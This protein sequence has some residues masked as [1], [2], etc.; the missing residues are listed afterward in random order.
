MSAPVQGKRA[1]RRAQRREDVLDAAM[2]IIVGEG[3]EALTIQRL[4]KATGASVGG[5]YRYYDSKESVVFA[6]QLRAIAVFGD[7]LGAE[8]D[9]A[10]SFLSEQRPAVDAKVGATFFPFVASLAYLRFEHR[11]PERHQLLSAFLCAKSQM[12]PE[13]SA[14]QV[15]TALRPLVMSIAEHLENAAARGAIGRGDSIQRTFLLWAAMHGLDNFRKRDRVLPE[16]LR[17]PALTD[18]MLRAVFTGWGAEPKVIDAAL[19]LAKQHGARALAR[20]EAEQR[21]AAAELDVAAS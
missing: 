11:E 6:L 8:L 1:Q 2:R 13:A 12:L 10:K 9:H 7:V 20:I 18:E 17:V 4:A 16:P 5:L 3:V 14:Q 19:E 21:A 15:D